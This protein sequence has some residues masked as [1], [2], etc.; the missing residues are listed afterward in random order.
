ML[1]PSE[2]SLKGQGR[3]EEEIEN[4]KWKHVVVLFIYH[5]HTQQR[6]CRQQLK[7][8]LGGVGEDCSKCLSRDK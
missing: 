4:R 6:Q 3:K 7:E 1:I 8:F 2:N 5:L